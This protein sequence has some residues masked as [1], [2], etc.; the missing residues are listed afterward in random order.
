M[1]V[2]PEK[3]H[4]GAHFPPATRQI[5]RRKKPGKLMEAPRRHPGDTQGHPR[6]HT[7]PPRDTQETPR[8]HPR[9]TQETSHQKDQ[10]V[11]WATQA[12][13]D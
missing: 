9:S 5:D 6:R 13:G 4:F 12:P 3:F 8:R 2:L 10:K 1:K 11:L 7:G